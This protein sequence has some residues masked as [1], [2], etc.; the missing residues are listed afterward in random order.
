MLVVDSFQE[1]KTNNLPTKTQVAAENRNNESSHQKWLRFSFFVL[2]CL[3]FCLHIR[4]AAGTGVIVNDL[5]MKLQGGGDKA[6]LCP[7]VPC[8]LENHH[9][10]RVYLAS[11][12]NATGYS[13][14]LFHA[15]THTLKLQPIYWWQRCIAPADGFKALRPAPFCRSQDTP[16]LELV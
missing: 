2:F 15:H 10:C 6:R 7:F 9:H 4:T 13:K 1:G 11:F 16:A 14:T 3:L 5:L 8:C 12:N